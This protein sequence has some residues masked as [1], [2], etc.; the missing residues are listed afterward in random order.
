MRFADNLKEKI[1]TEN[2][3][4]ILLNLYHEFPEVF[5]TLPNELLEQ[6]Y[7]KLFKK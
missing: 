1:M 2:R 5:E 3:Y 4:Q 6:F 7:A